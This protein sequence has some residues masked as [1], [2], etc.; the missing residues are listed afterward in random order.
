M[1]HA[2]G[3]RAFIPHQDINPVL[4][5]DAYDRLIIFWRKI[6]SVYFNIP[7]GGGVITHQGFKSMMDAAF[8]NGFAFIASDD[9][10]P[11]TKEDTEISPLMKDVYSY[12][13]H[14]V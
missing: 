11:P 10:T 6:A 5:A 7:G 2:K 4:I 12:D 8:E 9:K 3:D 14:G 1:F 13:H